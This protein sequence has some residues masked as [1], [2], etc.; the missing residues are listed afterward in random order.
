MGSRALVSAALALAACDGGDASPVDASVDAYIPGPCWPMDTTTPGGTI[1]LGTGLSSYRA[2]PDMLPLVYGDQNGYHIEAR[3]RITG[4]EPGDPLEVTK[5]TNPRTRYQAF[6]VEDG[7]AI[8]QPVFCPT[9][10]GYAPAA[11]GNGFT[12]AFYYEVRFDVGYVGA[13]IFG[14]QFRVVVEVIDSAGKYAKAEK[15]ITAL[16]PAT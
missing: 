5:P 16:P 6:F 9:R 14:K 10:L 2:M 15:T 7:R 4:L 12:S 8:D 13:D 3:A 11:D 1:E